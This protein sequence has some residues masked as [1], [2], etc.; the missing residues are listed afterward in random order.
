VTTELNG[1]PSEAFAVF[2]NFSKE[3]TNIFKQVEITLNRNKTMS[4]LH[5]LCI[6][7]SPRT[8]LRDY[9]CTERGRP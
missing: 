1:A 7:A 6:Y 4:S 2:K 5:F 8:L 3:A 9:V